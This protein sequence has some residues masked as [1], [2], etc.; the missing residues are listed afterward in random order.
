MDLQIRTHGTKVS[1]G[2]R[3]FIDRRMAKL[4]RIAE[5]VVEASLELRTEELRKGREV[6]TAQLTLR[7][8][9][10]VLR[11]EER[12][13]E[14]AK[15]IDAAID[16]LIAQVR[17]Y[18]DKRADRK[19]RSQRFQSD[20]IIA[21]P[22]T[23]LTASADAGTDDDDTSPIVRTKRFQMKPMVVEEAIDQ[24]ELIGHEFFL[25]QN[26]DEDQL[27]VLYRRRDGTFG[28]LAPARG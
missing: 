15:A 24:M 22:E 4:D 17:R 19:R 5:H 7:T 18:S 14:A 25:F 27:N 13:A 1:D 12:D 26:A 10:H 11:A 9:R 3:Q 6:T 16:T 23:A 28:L 2:L 8:G 21:S 20:G